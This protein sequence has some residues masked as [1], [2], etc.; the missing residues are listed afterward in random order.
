MVIYINTPY[1][2]LMVQLLTSVYS[3]YGYKRTAIRRHKSSN[4]LYFLKGE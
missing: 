1:D 3:N 4:K 2:D